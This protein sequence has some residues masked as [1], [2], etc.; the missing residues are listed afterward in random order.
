LFKKAASALSALDRS[1]SLDFR[2]C[3]LAQ[4][5]VYRAN[6]APNVCMLRCRTRSQTQTTGTNTSCIIG[7]L[8]CK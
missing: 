6:I 3:N 4:E 2:D 5:L 7:R 8:T 1:T